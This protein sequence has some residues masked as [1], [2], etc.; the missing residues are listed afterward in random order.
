MDSAPICTPIQQLFSAGQSVWLDYIRRDLLTSGDLRRKV[1]TGA[2][3]GLTSNPTIFEKAI[4]GSHD[5]DE[6]FEKLARAGESP[7]AILDALVIADIQGA[8]DVL[9]PVFDRTKGTDGF[10]S[11]EVSP[12]LARSTE[13][14]LAEARRL[15]KAVARPNVMVKIPATAEGVPAIRRAIGE[16]I[17]INITLIFSVAIYERVA[18]A[19]LAGLEDWIAKGGDPAKI[20]SVASFFV[21]R[22]DTLVDKLLAE[23][24]DK[25]APGNRQAVKELTGT[26]AVA[27]ARVAY[28]RFQA[29]FS[30]PRW[31]ALAAKGARVQRPLWASTGTK[32]KAYSDVKYVA[33]LVARDT[34]NTMP[35]D[36]IDAFCDHGTVAP[37]DDASI[38]A[39]AKQLARLEGLGISLAAVCDQ[40]ERDGVRLFA[41]SFHALMDAIEARRAAVRAA[42]PEGLRASLGSLGPAIETRLAELDRAQVAKR[43][44]ERDVT[45][46]SSD[47][48]VGR[49][50]AN[51]LGWLD[52]PHAEPATL[53]EFEVFADEVAREGFTDAVVLG[54]GG[55]SLCPDLWAR[56]FPVRA[57]RLRLHVLD[58]TDPHAVERVRQAAPPARTLY[59]VSTKSGNTIETLSFAE[60]FEAEVAAS[61]GGSS[62]AHFVA[63]TDPG[64]PLETL[65]SRRGWR[66]VFLSAPDVGGRFSALAPFGLLPA[67][68]LGLPLV[69][70]LSRARTM[71]IAAGP[72]AGAARTNAGLWLGAVIGEATRAGRDKLTLVTAPAIAALAAWLEQLVAEST[73]KEGQG[74]VPVA[75][76]PLGPPERYGDDRL[77][78]QIRLRDVKEPETDAALDALEKAG[79][80]VVRLVLDDPLDVAG[81]FVRWEVATAI[82]AHVLGVNAFDEPNVSQSKENTQRA[83]KR[84]EAGEPFAT[85]AALVRDGGVALFSAGVHGSSL[86][87]AAAGAEGH[88]E[89]NGG[90]SALERVLA[91]HFAS[92]GPGDY[93]ALLAYA[94]PTPAEAQELAR[95]RALLFERLGV[96]TTLGLG[97]R[98]LHSTGQL[99]KGGPNAGVF[100]VLTFETLEDRPVPGEPWSFGVLLDAQ[101]AGD[102]EA[103]VEANRRVLRAHLEGPRTRSLAELRGALERALRA[104]GTAPVF[105]PHA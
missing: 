17:N 2:L 11:I 13:E 102:V 89:G 23:R 67:A 68:L 64:S 71:A 70:L 53:A 7:D 85:S 18:E 82:A 59:V 72:R 92:I 39:A 101:A 20:T 96:A 44:S 49:A 5:Y 84:F 29:I 60:A 52:L 3:S 100:L 79:H 42:S 104:H 25:D 75:G 81:E 93:T 47:P 6:A 77:F 83:L 40:L 48:I 55:S 95:L 88:A 62:G 56:T 94:D 37:F 38:Q 1:E 15:W 63:I 41:D 43:L 99:H 87:P 36:T 24:D 19:Y 98:Y 80:P 61:N 73:G 12:L 22:V 16:G 9:R 65:A 97:P 35:P 54:M 66:R 27:N 30:G 10:A 78:V 86:R 4:A 105:T 28:G 90:S 58:L 103:L 45:L 46:W 69:D 26:I 34:V 14:T 32:N 50:I 51:R 57:G 91:A 33:E 76:E 21:S 8:C 74:V 31:D